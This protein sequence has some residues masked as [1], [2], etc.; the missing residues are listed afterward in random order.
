M[1]ASEFEN[2]GSNLIFASVFHKFDGLSQVSVILI[3]G[4]ADFVGGLFVFTAPAECG[5]VAVYGHPANGAHR[6]FNIIEAVAAFKAYRFFRF[7]FA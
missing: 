2:D 7:G 6:W 5:I 1:A 4:S 3:D